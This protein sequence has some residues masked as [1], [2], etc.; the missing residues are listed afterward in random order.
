VQIDVHRKLDY[1][2]GLSTQ[3]LMLLSFS[4]Q[5][6]TLLNIRSCDLMTNNTVYN[7]HFGYVFIIMHACV[8]YHVSA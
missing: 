6:A 8:Y 3:L 7:N 4:F 2:Y 1:F 5:L